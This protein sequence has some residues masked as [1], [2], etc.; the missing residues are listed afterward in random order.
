MAGPTFA[1]APYK[2]PVEFAPEAFHCREIL[3]FEPRVR[4]GGAADENETDKMADYFE[5][6]GY[7]EGYLAGRKIG[8][9]YPNDVTLNG[10]WT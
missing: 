5:A 7:I 2:G 6:T 8:F 4:K 1:Q 10:I 9:P 3:G